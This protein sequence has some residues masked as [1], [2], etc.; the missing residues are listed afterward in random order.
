MF[1]GS[2]RHLKSFSGS[3]GVS[4]FIVMC[5]EIFGKTFIYKGGGGGGGKG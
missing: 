2:Q 1:Y 3:F 5:Y 4:R